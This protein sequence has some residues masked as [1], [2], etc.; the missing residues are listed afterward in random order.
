MSEA[1]VVK[2]VRAQRRD[3]MVDLGGYTG[4]S[5]LTYMVHRLAPK[6]LTWLGC[7]GTTGMEQIEYRVTDWTA[8]PEGFDRNYTEKLPCTRVQR[9]PPDRHQP[10]E[11]LRPALPRAADPGAEQRL[12]DITFGSAATPSLA[13]SKTV[14]L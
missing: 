7:P 11:D 10:A 4:A 9:L 1:E 5:P 6:Q 8:D 14:R 2:A 3:V 13:R 12:H